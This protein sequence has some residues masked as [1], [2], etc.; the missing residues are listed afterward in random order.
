MIITVTMRSGTQVVIDT[1]KGKV[2][3]AEDLIRPMLQSELDRFDGT[4]QLPA[5]GDPERAFADWIAYLFPTAK[6]AID[7]DEPLEEGAVY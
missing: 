2:T 1:Q 7:G 6:I 5:D 3:S 4:F